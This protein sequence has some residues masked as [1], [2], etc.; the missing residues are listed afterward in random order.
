[1]DINWKALFY[2]TP[3][4]TRML[5]TMVLII[6]T[7]GI[8]SIIVRKLAD[9][10]GM[11]ATTRRR[12]IGTVRNATI[13]VIIAIVVVIWLAQLRAI[14][15]TVVV[16][17]AAI[18]VA[19]KEFLLNFL[20][21]IYQ[22]TTKFVAIGD[23]IEMDN[24]RGDVIDQGLLGMTLMEIGSGEKIHQ[25]TGL[26]VYVPNSKFLSATI[27]NET[28]MW[29]NYVFHLITIPVSRGDTWELAE[30]ALLRAGGECCK[31]Y[32]ES[33]RRLMTSMAHHESL[34]APTVEPRVHVQV[35]APDRTNLVLRIPVPTRQRGRL[36]REV[37]R[38][39]LKILEEMKAQ[40]N[41]PPER[42]GSTGANLTDGGE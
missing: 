30:Q 9:L 2:D 13:I 32:L 33:A 25:Y 28:R 41:E 21:Y 14:A 11:E 1:M 12:W 26:T 31:P 29:G 6:I 10:E 40:A 8:R 16:V 37:T 36:E 22:S 3:F 18:V 20:G 19:T 38:R 23:R 39:Y 24:I 27:K 4:V 34:E 42:G 5:S 15:A 17:A 35:A 7:L